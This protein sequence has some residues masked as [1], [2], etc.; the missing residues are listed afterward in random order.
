[1]PT[2][3]I[4]KLQVELANALTETKLCTVHTV[5]SKDGDVRMLFTVIDTKEKQLW[6]KFLSEL[7]PELQSHEEFYHFVGTK[8]LMDGGRMVQPWVF[9]LS[10]V[11]GGEED[12]AVVVSDVR[13]II[14]STLEEMKNDPSQPFNISIPAPWAATASRVKK[15][16]QPIK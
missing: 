1:M 3:P 12:L 16:V 10:T 8:V 13:R 7:L 6:F 9:I 14:R 5:G 4:E 2:K 11:P 15:G